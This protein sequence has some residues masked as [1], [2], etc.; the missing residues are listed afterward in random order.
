[1]RIISLLLVGIFAIVGCDSID[2]VQSTWRTGFDISDANDSGMSDSLKALYKT[3]AEHL[4]LREIHADPT[5][6]YSLVEIPQELIDLYYNSLLHIYNSVKNSSSSYA[7]LGSIHVFPQPETHNLVLSVDTTKEWV[8]QLISGK[9]ITGYNKVDNL[10][11]EYGLKLKFHSTFG[12][13]VVLKS[14]KALN[15]LALAGSFKN[16]D[17][18]NICEPDGIVG[19]GNDIVSEVDRNQIKLKYYLKWGDCPAGCT[20]SHV[21]ILRLGRKGDVEFLGES[22]SDIPGRI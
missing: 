18:I 6:K 22:G 11:K 13:L 14:E 17:G 16:L 8:R 19:D 15:V 10:I 12:P 1:M 2:P 3:D 7:E 5:A 20:A 4:A 9:E 21:W